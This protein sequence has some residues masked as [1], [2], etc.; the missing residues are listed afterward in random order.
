M[1]DFVS[2]SVASCQPPTANHITNNQLQSG[3]VRKRR[4]DF[5]AIIVVTNTCCDSAETCNRRPTTNCVRRFFLLP[6]HF[7]NFVITYKLLN[8]C[9]FLHFRKYI[10]ICHCTFCNLLTTYSRQ[11]LLQLIKMQF[12]I[13]LAE[14]VHL[15][16]ICKQYGW[17]AS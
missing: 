14:I 17:G 3:N 6:Y 8:F 13:Q 16:R 7:A 4:R 12:G 15:I 5:N 9:F 10:S 11:M 2:C 1:S